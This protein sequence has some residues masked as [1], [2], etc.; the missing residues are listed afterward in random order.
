[1]WNINQKTV[2]FSKNSVLFHNLIFGPQKNSTIIFQNPISQI[3]FFNFFWLGIG[4]P[5][6]LFFFQNEG[7]SWD[8]PQKGPK[9]TSCLGVRGSKSVGFLNICSK[10]LYW[11]TKVVFKN[12]VLLFQK[13]G[14]SQKAKVSPLVE[15]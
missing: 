7:F 11:C 10:P 8:I 1:M 4:P 6:M 15:F 13:N 3:W 12:A 14:S 9:K 2:Q 5:L